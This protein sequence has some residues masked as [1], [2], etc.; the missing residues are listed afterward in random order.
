MDI[1]FL[2]VVKWKDALNKAEEKDV[3]VVE[4]KD[5]ELLTVRHINEDKAPVTKVRLDSVR[6]VGHCSCV[7]P[8]MTIVERYK[9]A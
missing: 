9:M 2:D 4:D 5:G 1:Q 3:M 8:M 6:K 7:E